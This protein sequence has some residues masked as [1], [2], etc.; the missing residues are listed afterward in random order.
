[1]RILLIDNYDSFTYNLVHDLERIA[2][3]H[4]EVLRND[5][6]HHLRMD[7]DAY[8]ISPGPGLPNESGNLMTFMSKLA[9]SNAPVLGVC[10]GFQ[11]MVEHSGGSLYN[12]NHVRHGMPFPLEVLETSPLYINTPLSQEVGLYHSWAVKRKTL[13][14]EWLI[15]AQSSEGVVMSAHHHTLPWIGVQFHPESILTTNGKEILKNW[16]NHIRRTSALS[17]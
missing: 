8:V 10:L 7:F 13:P 3:L 4:V 17:E 15:S 16:V 12:L 6:L 2:N 1:M 11:A 9:N 5:E 14:S